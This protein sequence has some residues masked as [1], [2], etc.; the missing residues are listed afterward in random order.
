MSLEYVADAM[1][2][3][4]L[5]FMNHIGRPGFDGLVDL[6]LEFQRRCWSVG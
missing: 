4:Q 2:A 3:V 6:D 1:L 5:S